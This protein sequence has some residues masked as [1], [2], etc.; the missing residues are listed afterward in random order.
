[1]IKIILIRGLPGSGKT[2]RAKALM[3]G[4]GSLVHLESDAW[5]EQ[6]GAYNFNPYELTNSHQWCV[7]S[8]EMA[9]RSGKSVIVSNVFA[10]IAECAPYFVLKQK[11]DC[12]ITVITC[13]DAY[14]SM[15]NVPQEK[16]EAMR[17]RFQD[18]TTIRL[19]LDR[20]FRLFQNNPYD[21]YHHFLNNPAI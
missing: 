18:E 15:H 19:V 8:S 11:Y 9:L 4:A 3:G 1:M 12:S 14:G 7:S 21:A 17:A 10:S 13:L 6:N 5:F 2:T 20:D 16:I